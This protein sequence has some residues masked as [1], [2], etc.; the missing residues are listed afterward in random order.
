[1]EL[2]IKILKEYNI[3][4]TDKQISQYAE[5]ME[6]ILEYNEHINLTSITDRDEFI[7]KHYVDSILGALNDEFQ[8]GE[9]II[10]V[11]TGAGFPG[12]PLAILFPEK[13]FV[14]LDSLNKRL[15]IVSEICHSAVINNV[16]VLH[17]RAEDAGK[18]RNT[19]SSL[20]YVYQER[21]Q[22]CQ[23]FQS[24]VCLL[25]E[26][27]DTSFPTR[28]LTMRRNWQ[29]PRKQSGLWEAKPQGLK[30]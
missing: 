7:K 4:L 21:L 3:E 10:D 19:E 12:V 22:I 2:L 24:F 8:A 16:R 26:R 9:M 15:K 6:Q 17:S 5:Y 27:E 18:T 25:S 30:E 29:A 13:E 1:M 11:G 23:Y 28:D 20:I 14:L